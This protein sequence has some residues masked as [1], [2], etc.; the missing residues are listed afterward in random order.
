MNVQK[1]R[2]HQAVPGSILWSLTW[3]GSLVG[4]FGE[5]CPVR[6]RVTRFPVRPARLGHQ[7]AD[8][9]VVTGMRADCDAEAA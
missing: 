2:K 4:A 5:P 6:G 7:H 9:H 1:L 3:L 8:D